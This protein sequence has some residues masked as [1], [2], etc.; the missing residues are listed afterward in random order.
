[1]ICAQES[2]TGSRPIN[3]DS[4]P[5]DYVRASI[6]V[7]DPG[8]ALYSRVGH[9][10]IHM[11]CP[12]HGLDFVFSAEAEPGTGLLFKFLSGSLRMG[13]FAVP[14]DE[15]LKG[16][17]MDGRS[18]CEYELLLPIKV[19]QNLWRVLDRHVEVGLSLPYDYLER[20]CSQI[21]FQLLT[22]ALDT[23]HI[24][25][26]YWPESFAM[27]R[28][29]IMHHELVDSPWVRLFLHLL[30]NG[31]I[32]DACANGRKVLVPNDLVLILQHASLNGSPILDTVP[33]VILDRTA[34]PR[35]KPWFTPTM[36]AWLMLILTLL[37]VAFHRRGM[38]YVLL[39]LQTL[40]G[41]FSLYLVAFSNLCCTEWSWLLIPF[42]PLPALCWRWR[43]VW[44][45]PYAVV[46]LLWVAAMAAWPH[47]LTD[48]PYIL[49]ASASAL[50]YIT[51]PSENKYIF[52]KK[53]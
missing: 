2:D 10:A 39:A 30:I 3:L 36:L 6:V 25:F 46:I 16:Y 33:N 19:K 27:S 17:R 18:V 44:A 53:R 15:Y 50:S 45:K 35:T 51:L 11:Q 48:T 26:G 37:S 32:D 1:M 12:T 52:G 29:E 9:A 49:L 21:T 4:V 42:N 31:S 41:C 24:E 23:C 43:H 40:L 38:D 20:G 28:R 5:E 13:V 34:T 14:I 22:E 8:N 47:R 7:A